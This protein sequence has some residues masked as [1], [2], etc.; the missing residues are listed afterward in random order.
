MFNILSHKTDERM[1][2]TY[3]TDPYVTNMDQKCP[4]TIQEED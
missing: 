2:T 4:N 3:Y 1:N